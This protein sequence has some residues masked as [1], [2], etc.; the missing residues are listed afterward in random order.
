MSAPLELRHPAGTWQRLAVADLLAGGGEVFA[1]L[2]GG[3]VAVVYSDPPWNPGN[4]KWWR[5]HAGADPPRNYDDLL[6]A[7]CGCVAA[8][9]LLEHVFCEQ[10]VNPRHRAMLDAAVARCPG[11]R[12]PLLEEWTVYYGSPGSRGCSRPNRLL[13]FGHR[14]LRT[15]PSGLRGEAM[16]LRVFDGF[17][18][19][20]G[21]VVGDPCV[22]KGMTSR[23]AHARGWSC[24]GTELNPRRLAV[25]AAWLRARGYVGG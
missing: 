18:L 15:E 10:S 6:D 25:A 4:E 17:D 11:W 22:G 21:T 2:A 13:H 3:R 8:C 16:T 14:P 20:E 12:L 19:P 24:V 1:S 9:P 7:W 5:R 23:V